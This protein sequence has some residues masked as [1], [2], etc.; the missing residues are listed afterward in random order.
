MYLVAG[1]RC[2]ATDE[3]SCCRDNEAVQATRAYFD[4]PLS[5]RD[6]TETGEYAMQ[7][8]VLEDSVLIGECFASSKDALT[9]LPKLKQ[10]IGGLR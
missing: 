2:S 5:Y 6:M 10:N 3:Q 1:A 9:A 8:Q 7:K 4:Q